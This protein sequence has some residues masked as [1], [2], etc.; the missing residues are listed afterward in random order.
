MSKTVIV[1]LDGCVFR[2]PNT[3]DTTLSDIFSVGKNP[4]DDY[5]LPGVVEAFNKWYTSGY[6][7]VILTGRPEST[8][9]LTKKQLA[10]FNLFYDRMIMG[11][12]HYPRIVIND[13]K[14]NGLVTAIACPIERNKGLGG[15]DI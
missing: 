13:T 1:D 11:V 7:I 10:Y 12:K 5:L 9:E 6:F 14:P 4:P 2:H 8:R 15:L 3:K